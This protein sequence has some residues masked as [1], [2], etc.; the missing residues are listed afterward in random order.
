[1]NGTDT[2]HQAE[3]R[4][5]G[6]KTMSTAKTQE[7]P[8]SAVA[9]S[10]WLGRQVQIEGTGMATVTGETG[11][12]IVVKLDKSGLEMFVMKYDIEESPGLWAP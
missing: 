12:G 7:K 4:R 11:D 8:D 2:E 3:A 10:G 5:D 6:R 1:M 9:S